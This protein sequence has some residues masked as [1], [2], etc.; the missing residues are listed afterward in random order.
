M[1]QVEQGVPNFL[2]VKKLFVLHLR[3]A[4]IDPSCKQ[5]PR[6]YEIDGGEEFLGGKHFRDI[7]PK[8]AGKGNQNL[9]NFPSLGVLKLPDLV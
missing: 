7:G 3:S 5:S 6:P 9:D 2:P 4:G 8:I 1:S